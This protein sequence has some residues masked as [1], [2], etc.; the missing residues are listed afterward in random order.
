MNKK[1]VYT[2]A[3]AFLILIGLGILS[4]INNQVSLKYEVE[5][6]KIGASSNF[7]ILIAEKKIKASILVSKIMIVTGVLGLGAFFF[8]NKTSNNKLK[9]GI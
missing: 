7:D 8:I 5:E 3:V 1:L 6:P 2:F 9:T 4:Y